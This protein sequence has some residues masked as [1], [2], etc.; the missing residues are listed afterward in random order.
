MANQILKS[1]ILETVENQLQMD[2]P[3]CIR[4]T[5]E[6]LV[7]SGYIEKEA[8]EM[9]GAVLLEDI[10]YILMDKQK[11]DEKKYSDKLN[12]LPGKHEI[13]DKMNTVCTILEDNIQ[14]MLK[15]VEYNTGTF[16]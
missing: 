5:L 1:T 3:I 12:S 9:I 4:L 7:A 16:P 11:F 6:R 10:Y 14:G 13:Y 15:Q 8:K 2:D